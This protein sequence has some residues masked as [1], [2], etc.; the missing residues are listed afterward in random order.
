M[1]FRSWIMWPSPS[2]PHTCPQMLWKHPDPI[3][4]TWFI[5]M[6]S[7]CIIKHLTALPWLSAANL[8]SCYSWLRLRIIVWQP[9]AWKQGNLNFEIKQSSTVVN[10]HDN[11]HKCDDEVSSTNTVGHLV[12]CGPQTSATC[13][14][15]IFSKHVVLIRLCLQSH[16]HKIGTSMWESCK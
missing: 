12:A 8:S 4:H 5:I 13:A 9:A 3:S 2:P 10:L 14:H 15:S 16:L 1:L 6:A 11:I 7:L